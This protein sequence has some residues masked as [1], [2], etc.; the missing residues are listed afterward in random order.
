MQIYNLIIL[1]VFSLMMI[2]CESNVNTSNDTIVLTDSIAKIKLKSSESLQE[3]EEEEVYNIEEEEETIDDE[4]YS[5]E[6][7]IDL[8]GEAYLMSGVI[9]DIPIYCYFWDLGDVND[10]IDIK[11]VYWYEGQYKNM[12]I[13]GF[14]S[15]KSQDLQFQRKEKEF[16]N[17][18][19]FN[20]NSAE[21]TWKKGEKT[22]PCKLKSIGTNKFDFIACLKQ[23]LPEIDYMELNAENEVILDNNAAYAQDKSIEGV[24]CDVFNNWAFAI[25]EHRQGSNGGLDETS[26][27][28]QWLLGSQPAILYTETEA[29]SGRNSYKDETGTIMSSQVSYTHLNK[30]VLYYIEGNGWTSKELSFKKEIQKAI[31][32]VDELG[33]MG[34]SSPIHIDVKELQ[35]VWDGTNYSKKK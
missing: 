18:T 23:I 17:L 26:Y 24:S 16:F 8:K 32:E 33:W 13:E 11:G 3:N 6:N 28:W 31:A 20:G 2:S 5:G 15:T 10:T 27:R 25:S 34:Q 7:Y 19:K 1:F 4:G 22:L 29:I 9:G 35:W 14:Y 21:G 30:L 12:P